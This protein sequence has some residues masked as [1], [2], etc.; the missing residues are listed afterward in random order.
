MVWLLFVK[1]LRIMSPEDAFAG[2]P[3]QPQQPAAQ[4]AAEEVERQELSPEDFKGWRKFVEDGKRELAELKLAGKSFKSGG[5]GFRVQGIEVFPWVSE[6]PSEDLHPAQ[7]EALALQR[8]RS[9][10]EDELEGRKEAYK[11]W[12]RQ[13]MKRFPS[14]IFQYHNGPGFR[15]DQLGEEEEKEYEEAERGMEEE[16]NRQFS[17]SAEYSERVKEFFGRIGEMG[18]ELE[19]RIVNGYKQLEKAEWQ[20]LYGDRPMEHPLDPLRELIESEDFENY[21]IPVAKSEKREFVRRVEQLYYLKG[22]QAAFA[23]LADKAAPGGSGLFVVGRE[24]PW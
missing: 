2:Q 6:L 5:G 16:L 19:A 11:E 10:I 14:G 21:F 22:P 8:E 24:R 7:A 4:A 18:D 12:E 9:E 20:T 1:F 17:R 3:Q 23:Y 13:M 15:S